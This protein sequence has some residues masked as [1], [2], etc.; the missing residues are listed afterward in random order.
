MIDTSGSSFLSGQLALSDVTGNIWQGLLIPKSA[1]EFYL[2]SILVSGTALAAT[3]LTSTVP[4]TWAVS[5]EIY[6][7][8]SCRCTGP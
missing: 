8:F 4:F 2:Y 7:R 5:D 1:T 6:Y 3:S